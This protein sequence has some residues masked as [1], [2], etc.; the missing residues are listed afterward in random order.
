[1]NTKS[2]KVFIKTLKI[3]HPA[4]FLYLGSVFKNYR[5][6]KLKTSNKYELIKY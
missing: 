1:M 5:C 4:Y 6:Q 2:K 3:S